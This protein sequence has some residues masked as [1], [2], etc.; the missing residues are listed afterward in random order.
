MAVV[1]SETLECACEG[2][3]ILENIIPKPRVVFWSGTISEL[4]AI[5]PNDNLPTKVCFGGR[6]SKVF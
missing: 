4:D 2:C 5:I 6:R 3:G 1:D